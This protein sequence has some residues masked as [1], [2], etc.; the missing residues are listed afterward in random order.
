MQTK[1]Y[2][3]DRWQKEVELTI[4]AFRTVPE[5]RADYR[6]H[7]KA[8]SAQQLADHITAHA[9]DLIQGF[10]TPEVNHDVFLKYDS[11]AE[12]CEG[13][14]QA[15]RRV[16]AF[17]GQTDENTWNTKI[18]PVFAA[19]FKMYDL[20]LRELCFNWLLDMVHHRGQLS[21]YYRA[22]GALPP[23]IY[24]PNAEQTEAMFAQAAQPA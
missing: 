22:M 3:T 9:F 14:E 13:L 17:L 16:I 7:P 10:E 5:E 21:T 2:F 4:N 1:Q 12:A 15:S 19:G 24:G 8:R 11:M 23:Y 18:L 20:S 6:P